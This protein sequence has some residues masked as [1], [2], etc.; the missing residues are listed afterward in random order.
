[1]NAHLNLCACLIPHAII[2][3]F[4]AP[5]IGE[6]DSV[7]VNWVVAKCLVDEVKSSMHELT[8]R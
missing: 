2:D 5:E 8:L 6:C 3:L 1:M 4:K 7:N